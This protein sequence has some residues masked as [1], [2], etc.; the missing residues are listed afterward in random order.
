MASSLAPY[1]FPP[2]L[3]SASLKLR[4]IL[5]AII[6]NLL[7]R[8]NILSRVFALLISTQPSRIISL[9]SLPVALSLF[10]PST[11]LRCCLDLLT[12]LIALFVHMKDFHPRL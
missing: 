9:G 8:V 2:P 12:V 3:V 6:L 7:L 10:F 4:V 1:A 11:L 5:S